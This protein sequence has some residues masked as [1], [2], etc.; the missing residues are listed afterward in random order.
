MTPIL[1]VSR[2]IFSST[3]KMIRF[4]PSCPFR[5]FCFSGIAAIALEPSSLS[6]SLEP[7]LL[8]RLRHPIDDWEVEASDHLN[9]NLLVFFEVFWLA[10]R[11][12]YSRFICGRQ[13]MEWVIY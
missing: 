8:G 3:S 7:R 2:V 6:N 11:L 13:M 12:V 1:F 4:T 9:L 10:W 5:E